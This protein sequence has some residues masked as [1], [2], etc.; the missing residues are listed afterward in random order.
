MRRKIFAINFMVFLGSTLSTAMAENESTWLTKLKVGASYDDNVVVEQLDTKPGRADMAALFGVSTEYRFVNSNTE[1]LSIGYDFSQSLHATVKAFD[2]QSHDV[3]FSN[4]TRVGKATIDM[5][6]TFYHLLLGGRNLLDMQVT[7]PG[8]LFPLTSQ[9]FVRGAY[10][11]MDKSFHD[12]TGRNASHHQPEL[13]AF[14]FFD[15]A[16]AYV[17]L[18]GDYEIENAKGAEFTYQGYALKASLQLPMNILS[19]A[20]KV[21]AAYTYLHRNY[22]NITASIGTKRYE[23]RST[24]KIGAKIPIRDRLNLLLDY[25]YVDRKSNL[26][27]ANYTENVVDGALSYEF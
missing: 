27:I 19:R 12:A 25:Q 15:H 14:Y 17:L 6:Y 18:G 7:D 23:L 11:Y 24:I 4:S 13:D 10:L 2:I 8:I 1:K 16:R 5:S 21:T 20:G 26:P 3:S 22:E 9:V